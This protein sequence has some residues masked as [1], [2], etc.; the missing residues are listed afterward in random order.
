[1][2]QR[3]NFFFILPANGKY[4]K[5]FS[6]VKCSRTSQYPPTVGMAAARSIMAG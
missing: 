4:A 2:V 5:I 3:Y 6:V 1:M